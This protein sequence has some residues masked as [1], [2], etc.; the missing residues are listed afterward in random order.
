MPYDEH[1]GSVIFVQCTRAYLFISTGSLLH[2]YTH[3]D[4]FTCATEFA[5]IRVFAGCLNA[6]LSALGPCDVSKVK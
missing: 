1:W 6:L 5:S 2:V 3:R 4:S